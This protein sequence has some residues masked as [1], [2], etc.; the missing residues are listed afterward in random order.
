M[1]GWDERIASRAM[2]SARKRDLVAVAVAIVLTLGAT[3]CSG[4]DDDDAGSSASSTSPGVDLLAGVV[5]FPTGDYV[6][7]EIGE[8]VEYPA[9]AYGSPPVWGTHWF[10]PGWA[11]CGFYASAIPTEAAVHSLE[12]GVVWIAYQRSL[13]AADLAAL[14][15]I[16]DDEKVMVS[17]VEG[18]RAPVVASA[19]GVQLDIPGGSD[20][21]VAAFVD[22]YTDA[23]E[24]PEAGSVCESGVVNPSHPTLVAAD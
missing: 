7:V 10:Q 17:P 20:P 5:V 6:H 15:A 2:H 8:T 19:W 11:D 12:H 13:P 21:A 24:A 4:D 9:E 23:S 18:L 14:E 3:A 22:E 16:A 1:R